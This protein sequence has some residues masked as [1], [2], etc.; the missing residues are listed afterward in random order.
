[1]KT[2]IKIALFIALSSFSLMAFSQ[3]NGT[4]T[5]T[6]TT[7][8]QQGTYNPNN[9]MAIW[10]T[11]ST[12]TFVKTLKKMGLQRVQYLTQWRTNSG[13]NVTDAITGS[14]LSNHQT[15]TVSWNCKNVSQVVVPDGDYKVW[16]E[17]TDGD[18]QGPYTSFSWTKG[19]TSQTLTPTNSKLSGITLTWTPTPSSVSE[20]N[21]NSSSL[22]VFP[23][24]F[25]NT[26]NFKVGTSSENC[27]VDIF[28]LL[29]KKVAHLEQ[30]SIFSADILTWDGCS[31]SGDLLKN[32]V[33]YYHVTVGKKNFSGKV[34]LSH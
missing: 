30:H 27:I 33:Y 10:I 3:T 19:P 23:N 4:L 29:G 20:N 26:L 9:I 5:F 7:I 13:S 2:T 12:G 17:F 31:M 32:G 11:N 28:D 18:Y 22:S 25:S 24:P 16:I 8:N 21:T 14:T 1:M 15:H 34:L 6:A